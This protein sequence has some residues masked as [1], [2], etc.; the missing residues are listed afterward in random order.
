VI[1]SRV[2]SLLR[3]VRAS[4]VLGLTCAV[5]I[6]S[7]LAVGQ[8]PGI[9]DFSPIHSDAIDTV[10]IRDGGILIDLP[11]WKKSALIPFSYSLQTQ[12]NVTDDANPYVHVSEFWR[13]GVWVGTVDARSPSEN[14]FLKAASAAENRIVN[15]ARQSSPHE[16][17]SNALRRASRAQPSP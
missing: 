17:R 6:L 5:F 8:A 3:H 4:D 15:T 12:V 11:I 16:A 2:R 9:P 7:S 14:C 1:G 13:P 10:K